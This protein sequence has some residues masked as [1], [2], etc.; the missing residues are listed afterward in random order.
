MSDVVEKLKIKMIGGYR[1]QVLLTE[2]YVW[3]EF[4]EKTP[5]ASAKFP[6]K[7]EQLDGKKV[8]LLIGCLFFF[9]LYYTF[10]CNPAVF[11]YTMFT[12]INSMDA[13]IMLE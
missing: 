4:S 10:C 7:T 3:D 12:Q 1:E 9:L 11:V 2:R 13:L 8:K 5:I 6:Y